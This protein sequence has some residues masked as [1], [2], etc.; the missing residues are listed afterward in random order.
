MI[1]SIDNMKFM[2]AMVAVLLTIFGSFIPYFI[3]IFKKK[4]KPHAYTWL[5]WTITQSIATAGLIYGRGGWGSL[6]LIIGT[7]FVFV[8]FLISLKYGTRNIT[9]SDTIVLVVVL[10]AIV[11]WL[12]M[13][14]PLLAVFMISAIDFLGYVPSFRK[15]FQEPWTETIMSWIIFSIG[16]I[17]VILSLNAYNLLTLTYVITITIANLILIAICLIRRKTIRPDFLISNK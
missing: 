4:T 6:E 10:L 5:I 12:Q 8:I 13:H 14:N 17:F 15:S 1:F 3:D 11:V 2:F 9:K 7:F 16:N